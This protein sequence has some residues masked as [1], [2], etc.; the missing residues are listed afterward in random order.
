GRGDGRGEAGGV[1]G[2]RD[3]AARGTRV[4]GRPA[5]W[6][7]AWGALGQGGAVGGASHLIWAIR[8]DVRVHLLSVQQRRTTRMASS[9]A[10]TRCSGLGGDGRQVAAR[11]LSAGVPPLPGPA[12][13]RRG[14]GSI[15]RDPR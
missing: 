7:R 4:E 8:T 14:A 2:R 11:P 13:L 3:L 15:R 12:P 9:S 10:S 1:Q 5:V 6:A